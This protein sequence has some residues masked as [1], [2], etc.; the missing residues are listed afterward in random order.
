M[1]A[2]NLRESDM[3]RAKNLNAKDGYGLDS[4]QMIHLI[5]AYQKGN[6]YKR[7]MIEYRLTDI[8][9]HNEVKMLQA[10]KF[11]ELRQQAK[12]W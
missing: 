1:A 7:A 6:D 9:F 12:E 8:N 11:D 10:G 2:I 3:R 4:L 5:N